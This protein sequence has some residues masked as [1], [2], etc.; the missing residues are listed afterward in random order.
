[1][2]METARAYIAEY[3]RRN[4][5]GEWNAYA[6]STTTAEFALEIIE[7][8]EALAAGRYFHAKMVEAAEKRM[9]EVAALQAALLRLARCSP[10]GSADVADNRERQEAHKQAIKAL[11]FPDPGRHV[12]SSYWDEAAHLAPV[13]AAAAEGGRQ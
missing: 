6:S 13:A 5:D 10:A 1:M 2:S 9:L 12:G 8:R 11:G 7:V 4:R 3:E